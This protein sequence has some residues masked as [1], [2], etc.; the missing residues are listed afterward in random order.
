MTKSKVS[1]RP[2]RTDFV[3]PYCS[4]RYKL[5]AAFTKHL[6]QQKKRFFEKDTK[7]ARLAFHAFTTFYKIQLHREVSYDTFA[8]SKLYEAFLKFG[9]YILDI[10]AI[11]PPSYIEYM[12]RS[13]VGIDKWC[14]DSEYEKYVSQ[15]M[16]KETPERGTERTLLLMEEWAIKNKAS[17][18]DFFRQISAPLAV[19]WIISGR[20]SPWVLLNSESGR[21]LLGRLSDEQTL[22]IKPALNIN[23]WKGKFTR[24]IKEVAD[25]QAVM[26]EYGI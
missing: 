11:D 1:K 25:I 24:H 8:K 5:E 6:C 23:M 21:E 12:V 22:L 2:S 10:D 26:K 15:L 3:C 17:I 4:K 13:G 7:A 20:I 16:M 19:R 18:S 14:R 9:K